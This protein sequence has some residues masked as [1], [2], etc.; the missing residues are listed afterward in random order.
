MVRDGYSQAGGCAWDEPHTQAQ[1]IPPTQPAPLQLPR[2]KAI[3]TMSSPSLQ[4]CDEGGQSNGLGLLARGAHSPVDEGVL[5]LVAL[6]SQPLAD[7]AAVFLLRPLQLTGRKVVFL[8]L[9]LHS[10]RTK[11]DMILP[12]PKGRGHCLPDLR[13]GW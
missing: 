4:G 3:T 6:P 8:S 13:G 5:L 10:Q 1:P 11:E 7:H 2:S 12:V 9:F